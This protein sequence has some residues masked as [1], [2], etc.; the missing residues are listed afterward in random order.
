MH[1]EVGRI[2]R[3][4]SVDIQALLLTLAMIAVIEL[5]SNTVFKIPLLAALLGV[6]T[7]VSYRYGQR[8][9]LISAAMISVYGIY[10]FST[11]DQLF[12]Y[13][14]PHLARL[15][16]LPIT[17]VIVAMAV[18]I[19]RATA[20]SAEEKLR[21]QLDFSRAIHDSL[22]EGVCAVDNQGRVTFV[23]AAA[24]QMLGWKEVELLGKDIHST[25]HF[26]RPDGTPYPREECPLLHVLRSGVVYRNHHDTF[27]RKNGMMFPVRYSSSP[28]VEHG[29]VEGAIVVF[30]DITKHKRA[31]EELNL[32]RL[33][34]E[35]AVD[36][37]IFR[38]DPHGYIASWNI[39][40]ERIKG[41]QAE[42]IIGQ[43]FS[44]FYRPEDR[45]R[46]K[47]EYVLQVA[48]TEGR[49]EEEGWRLRKD[50]L[51][52]WASVVVTALRDE[53]GQLTGFSKITRDLTERKRA[54]D[55]IRELNAVLERRVQERTRQLEEANQDLEAYSYSISHDLRAPLRG[56][57]GLA[58][59]LLEDYGDQL[60]Q[61]GQNY[62]CRIVGAAALMDQLI[63]DLLSYSRLS[64]VDVRLQP[65]NLR[66]ALDEALKQIEPELCKHRAQVIVKTDLPGIL[67]HPTILIQV[68]ANLL[69]N[70]VKFVAPEVQPRVEVWAEQRGDLVRLWVADNGIGIAQQDQDRVF[71]VFER[72]HGVETYPGSGIGLAIVRRGT[73]RMGGHVGVE[74]EPGHGSR[75]WIELLRAEKYN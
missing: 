13:T 61:T 36:Y 34:V 31:E 40:A 32:Y 43:H 62:A 18:G 66:L 4:Q 14:E 63:Q 16:L 46:G 2:N 50:G 7:Y 28:I 19:L 3:Q 64:R 72:L 65:V 38:L 27:I 30:H 70:A 54:E 56:M 59:A 57:Q 10:Y 44:R 24:E 21:H 25:I 60:N 45:A 8:S 15:I 73:E 58:Q 20:L 11:V 35:S 33:M 49:F 74:S 26:Q 39:G 48:A 29:Q 75:F 51:R 37:A 68:L 17:G 12:H 52:F 67:G 42:E 5:L 41:Y 1:V 23:N 9:G 71:N 22:G 69:T 47:P 6:I 55:E 53:H